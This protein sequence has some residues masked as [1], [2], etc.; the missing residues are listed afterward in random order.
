MYLLSTFNFPAANGPRDPSLT[1]H[2]TESS[3][4][5]GRYSF[6]LGAKFTSARPNSVSFVNVVVF[7]F[8]SLHFLPADHRDRRAGTGGPH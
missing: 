5:C 2:C 7:C 1:A 3:M 4:R 6:W 8:F